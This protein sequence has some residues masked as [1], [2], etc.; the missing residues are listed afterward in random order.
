[1]NKII[2]RVLIMAVITMMWLTIQGNSTT[3]YKTGFEAGTG[4]PVFPDA[5]GTDKDINAGY[6]GWSGG[7]SGVHVITSTDAHNDNQSLKLTDWGSSQPNLTI[8]TQ[9]GKDIYL[10][11]WIKCA[12]NG[13]YTYLQSKQSSGASMSE[14]K[15][16]TDA[17]IEVSADN[18]WGSAGSFDVTTNWLAVQIKWIWNSGSGQYDQQTFYVANI[19]DETWTTVGTKATRFDQPNLATIMIT[20]ENG[21]DNAFVDDLFITDSS[22]S[23]N[24]N[25]GIIYRTGFE[26]GTGSPAFPDAS[27]GDIDINAGYNGWSGGQAGY[28]VITSSDAH[29]GI[30]SLKLTDFGSSQPE[31]TLTTQTNRDIYLTFWTKCAANGEYTYIMLKTSGGA[32]LSDIKIST[33]ADIEVSADNAWVSAGS[34]DVGTNWF[35]V[36]IIW[37]WNNSSGKY[38]QQ[39]FNVANLGDTKWTFVGTKA[40]RF[41]QSDLA[42]I[43]ITKESGSDNVYIDDLTFANASIAPDPTS[44]TI[45]ETSFEAGTGMPTF[46]DASGGDMDI[47]IG[48]GGWSGGQSGVHVISSAAAQDGQQSFKATSWGTSQPINTFESQSGQDIYLRVWAKNPDPGSGKVGYLEMHTDNNAT[49]GAVRFSMTGDIEVIVSGSTWQSAGSF[50][51]T[52]E[53]FVMMIQYQWNGSL[54]KYDRQTIYA[55]NKYDKNWTNLGS[56]TV[57]FSQPD[58]GKL[59]YTKVAG[60]EACYIDNMVISDHPAILNPP[61][62]TMFRIL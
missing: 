36:Q 13:E 4:S 5:S 53:W 22:I 30:Q 27:G 59:M 12:A 24:P 31:N 38:D 2:T 11:F 42:K 37:A 1:M 32:A 39:T 3:I 10:T 17:D 19:G 56:T 8:A 16:S 45:Y 7:Q 62:G 23:P 58:I 55:A 54:H 18:V 6:G 15:I 21:S 25:P 20:K 60:T 34:F 49:L 52:S 46:P 26:E 33:D 48:Y 57:R 61:R 44:I 28:H 51:V 50:D 9:S 35:A 40:T 41:D 43:I 14:I 47:N 29:N